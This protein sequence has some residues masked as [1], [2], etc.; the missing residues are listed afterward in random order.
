[1]TP[2][3]RPGSE[4]GKI[5]LEA[6]AWDVIDMDG[7]GSTTVFYWDRRKDEAAT[8]NRRG[9]RDCMRPVA[10]NPGVFSDK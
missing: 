2:H 9:E 1:M 6:G 8:V 5:M 4:T 3:A 7:G 10:E